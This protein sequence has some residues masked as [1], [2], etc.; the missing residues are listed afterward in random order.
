[1]YDLAEKRVAVQMSKI[2]AALLLALVLV[3][4]G[5][6]PG[7]AKAGSAIN[8]SGKIIDQNIDVKDFNA[9]NAQGAFRLKISQ[10]EQFRVTLSTDDNLLNRVVIVLDRKTLRLSIEAPS[11]FFPTSLTIS[12]EMPQLTALN[13]SG[14][15]GGTIT[16]FSSQTP[17]SLILA[18]K[19]TLEGDLAASSVNFSLAGASTTVL[20]GGATNMELTATDSSKLDLSAFNLFKAKVNLDQKT[21]A[22][23]NVVGPFDVTLNHESNIFF[24]GNPVFINTSVANGSSMSMV[25]K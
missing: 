11:S 17:F 1:V 5:F 16:G 15:A 25:Q 22:I 18:D 2:I 8:G 20:R 14:G 19:G 7:C 10:A 24:L 3:G 12:L 23:V 13:F 4:A 6:L 21:E 9:I